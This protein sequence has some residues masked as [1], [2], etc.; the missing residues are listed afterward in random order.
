MPL[1]FHPSIKRFSRRRSE[2]FLCR[3]AAPSVVIG[4]PKC[5]GQYQVLSIVELVEYTATGMGKLSFF[6]VHAGPEL[7]DV[8]LHHEFHL[9]RVFRCGI[10]GHPSKTGGWAGGGIGVGDR[11]AK[12]LP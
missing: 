5:A 7:K 1:F 12:C 11:N 10:Q 8:L 2:A 4:C 3:E 6:V 9:K